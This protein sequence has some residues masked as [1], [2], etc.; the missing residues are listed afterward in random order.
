MSQPL[1][2]LLSIAIEAAIASALIRVLG[3]GSAA[4]A[5]ASATLGTILTHW[6]AWHWSPSVMAAIGDIPGFVAV[7]AGVT[8]V[9]AGVYR[10]LVP[11]GLGRALMLS[12]AANGG[13][14]AVGVILAAFNLL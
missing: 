2:M 10:F 9:E 11:V 6:F 12:L 14:A 13:S 7:E 5:A 1:A 8:V 4:R 3:W